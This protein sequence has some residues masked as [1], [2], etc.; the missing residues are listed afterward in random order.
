MNK[1]Q[2]RI[3]EWCLEQAAKRHMGNLTQQQIEKLESL[4]FPFVLCEEELDKLG[5]HWQA[6]NPNGSRYENIK[7]THECNCC[8]RGKK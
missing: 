6:N 4:N 8:E 7:K 1:D 3:Y 5:F 2:N